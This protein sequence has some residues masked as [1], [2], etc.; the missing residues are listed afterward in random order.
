MARIES[1]YINFL[2]HICWGEANIFK[3]FLTQ[4]FCAL[5]ELSY[6]YCD[7]GRIQL[8]ELSSLHSL[9]PQLILYRHTTNYSN[10]CPN[11]EKDNSKP[12]KNSKDHIGMTF[13]N[14]LDFFWKEFNTNFR[15]DDWDNTPARKLYLPLKNYIFFINFWCLQIN[16]TI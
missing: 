10:K 3:I 6:Q 7:W 13:K 5:S 12:A 4:I 1:L 2:S 9:P 8:I 14:E 15:N 16:N 11:N